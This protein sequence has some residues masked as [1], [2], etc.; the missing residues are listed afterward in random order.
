M[1]A[2]FVVPVTVTVNCCVP[3]L[4][5]ET[6]VGLTEIPTTGALVTVTVADADFVVSAALVALTV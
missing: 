5:S 6:V 4:S 3:P 2:V 1:T